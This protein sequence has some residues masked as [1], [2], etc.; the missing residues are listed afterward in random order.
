MSYRFCV[1]LVRRPVLM[2]MNSLDLDEYDKLRPREFN[3][4]KIYL[5]KLVIVKWP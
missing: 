5:N 3:W 4:S 2:K 1:S